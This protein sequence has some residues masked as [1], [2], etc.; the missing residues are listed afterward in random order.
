MAPSVRPRCPDKGYEHRKVRTQAS[1]MDVMMLLRDEV[2]GGTET[3]RGKNLNLTAASRFEFPRFL[4]FLHHT[5][6]HHIV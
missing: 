4:S 2:S 1:V 5:F 6:A 3:I